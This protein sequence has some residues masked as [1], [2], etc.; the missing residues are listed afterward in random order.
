MAIK[1]EKKTMKGLEIVAGEKQIDT[2]KAATLSQK[3]K[4]NRA[5]ME[6]SHNKDTR[7]PLAPPTS[8]QKC[9]KEEKRGGIQRPDLTA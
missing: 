8:K 3:K 9:Q 2:K 6:E 4:E 5:T 1:A 7:H